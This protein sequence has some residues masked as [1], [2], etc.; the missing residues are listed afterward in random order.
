M[1]SCKY[2]NLPQN[3]ERIYI[4]GF[5]DRKVYERFYFPRPIPLTTKLSDCINMVEPVPEIF[6]TGEELVRFT[7]LSL[8]VLS[9]V[10]PFTSGA[11]IMSVKTGAVSARL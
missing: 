1:N 7:R 9:T 8:Q 2:G 5:R 3:R 4:V 11:D 6:T 10:A